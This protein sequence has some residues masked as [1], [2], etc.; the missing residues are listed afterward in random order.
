MEPGGILS[1]AQR[2]DVGDFNLNGQRPRRPDEK[3][4]KMRRCEE[5][6]KMKNDVKKH[7]KNEWIVLDSSCRIYEKTEKLE[8]VFDV[9]EAVGRGRRS[10]VGIPT[11]KCS[12]MGCID[13][14]STD[15]DT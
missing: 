14:R 3:N 11:C 4:V 7:V 9:V 12:Q 13:I 10:V 1:D 5:Y 15:T 6:G 8:P 2:R